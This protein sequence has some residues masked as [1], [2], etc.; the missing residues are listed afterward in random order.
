MN[1]DL[2]V[3]VRNANP[4]P[5]TDHLTE[6]EF[7]AALMAIET[8]LAKH[9]KTRRLP[10]FFHGLRTRPTLVF[11]AAAVVV[12]MIIAVPLLLFAPREGEVTEPT[13]VITTVAPTT[14]VATT[15]T[16]PTTS[17]TVP[18]T[19][20]L[21]QVTRP[22]PIPQISW[23]RVPHQPA[24]DNAG[25]DG[26]FSALV[27]G[28][29]GLVG[30]GHVGDQLESLQAVIFISADGETW[31]R[32]DPPWVEEKKYASLYD[33]AA[34]ADGT[35]VAVGTDRSD[36]VVFAS[37]DGL[38]WIQVLAEA[39]GGL[40]LQDIEGVVAGGPG[41]VAV[42]DDGSDAGVWV[43]SDGYEWS[44]VLDEDLL[45]GDDRSVSMY[46]VAVGGPGLV[47]VGSADIEGA[48]TFAIW[49]SG[50]GYEWERLS[51]D[52]FGG[53]LGRNLES[54]ARNP[55]TGEL[56]AFGSAILTSNDGLSWVSI[57]Q[58][59]P[60][61]GPPP[62]VDVAWIGDTSVAGGRDMAFSLWVTGDAGSTWVRIDPE[63]PAFEAYAPQVGA[64]LEWN[65]RFIV[66]GQAGDYLSEVGAVWIGTPEE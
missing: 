5:T 42:G 39:L 55:A 62:N 15:T 22:A 56:T 29:P 2:G 66:G 11:A 20:T 4:V 46:D 41:F 7:S 61:G 9:P 57:D 32:I 36:A 21:A 54:L 65:G 49:T 1:N 27:Q 52:A 19:T 37:S 17:T 3:L 33:V 25:P 6:E 23:T 53:T 8:S 12:A 58:E 50:D 28:G 31:E 43:S 63:H 44:K 14:T 47:A 45:A 24:F 40:D 35:L 16:T 48:E 18:T 13:A 26:W 60:F 59:L 51:D 30:V 34:G 10:S 38:T 64:V